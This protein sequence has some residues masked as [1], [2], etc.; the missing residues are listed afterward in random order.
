MKLTT[1]QELCNKVNKTNYNLRTESRKFS[2]LY[3]MNERIKAFFVH[4]K[5]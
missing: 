1:P 4:I 2:W 3:L 5:L